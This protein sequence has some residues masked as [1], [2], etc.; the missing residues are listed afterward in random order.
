MRVTRLALVA[1]LL[2]AGCGQSVTGVAVP[3]PEAARQATAGLYSSSVKAVEKYIRET[4]DFRGTIF[5]YA[6]VNERKSGSDVDITMRGV[7]PSTI[8]KSRSKTPPGY[9]YDI[10]HPANDPLDYVR[11]G[12][13]YTSIAPTPW[14]SM[15]TTGADI[16]CAITGIQ[17]LCKIISALDATDKAPP[18]GRD[19]TGTRLPDGSTEVRTDITLKA[20]VDNAVINI[21]ADVAKLIDPELMSRLV[22][23]K[24]V[25]NSDRTLRKAE[26]R[27]EVRSAKTKV[28]VEVGY[29]SRG[30]SD[31]TDFPAAPPPG[32]I[33]ALP[34]DRAA[35]TDFWNRMAAVQK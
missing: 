15:Q 23:V 18:P 7:P 12:K 17:T 1:L 26:V 3:D 10:Y 8:I 4:R 28:Q 33:T 35:R 20:F 6:A 31:A 32:E 9:D 5:F 21:P 30:P 22:A 16:D 2:T 13:A 25:V 24:I 11:L 29:E 34:A 27:G 19:T 14:V